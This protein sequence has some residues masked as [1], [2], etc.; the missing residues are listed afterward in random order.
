MLTPVLQDQLTATGSVSRIFGSAYGV[1]FATVLSD[2]RVVTWDPEQG[3]DSKEVQ[4][5]LQCAV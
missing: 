5:E 3:D 4:A 1:A 2:G